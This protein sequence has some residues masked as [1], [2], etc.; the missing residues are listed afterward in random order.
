[1]LP[2]TVARLQNANGMH[3]FAFFFDAR[4]Q[5]IPGE[6]CSSQRGVDG[7]S[8]VNWFFTEYLGVITKGRMMYSVP[9]VASRSERVPGG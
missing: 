7:V 8:D 4:V 3:P 9:S 1:M 2:R 5:R 6:W